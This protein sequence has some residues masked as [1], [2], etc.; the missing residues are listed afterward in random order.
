M[1]TPGVEPGLSRPRHDVL[2]TG[3]CGP[4]FGSPA[5][6]SAEKQIRV[7]RQK[8][9]DTERTSLLCIT[10]GSSSENIRGSIVVSISARH[11]ED[12]G[13]IPG[14]GAFLAVL[15]PSCVRKKNAHPKKNPKLGEQE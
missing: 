14:R 15:E 5:T 3:R 13:S 9:D 7:A 12:P 10:N 4:L 1:T 11:A 8:Q 2:T 6:E